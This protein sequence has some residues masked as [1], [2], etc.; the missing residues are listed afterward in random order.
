MDKAWFEQMF[1]GDD[2]NDNW[3]HQY[4]ATQQ[5]RLQI[6]YRLLM[7]HL[8]DEHHK[9]GDLCCGLGDFI[10]KVP[11]N[12]ERYGYDISHN[13]IEKAKKIYPMINFSQNELPHIPKKL[14]I[15]ITLE[16]L[17]Y[18]HMPT[19]IQKICENLHKKGL[20]LVSIEANRSDE[21]DKLM[22]Q[23]FTILEKKYLYFGL[24]SK[25]EPKLLFY[26]KDLNYI[27][28]RKKARNKFLLEKLL[29]S[30]LSLLIKSSMKII[31]YICLFILKSKLI[32]YLSTMA[33][34]KSHIIILG[35]KK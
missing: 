8:S 20:F 33:W 28:E 14:D 4:R 26:T 30:K 29:N 24:F 17:S 7:K 19:A 9:I 25:L 1:E 22:N 15:I 12:K 18:L 16:C 3:G 31:Q 10:T 23:H 11:P 2:H 34:Q 32:A 35:T 13:A 6:S 27:L 21:L 5:L